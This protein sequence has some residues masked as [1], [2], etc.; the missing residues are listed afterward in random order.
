MSAM[1][2]SRD[3]N[4]VKH[5]FTY[6]PS[7]LNECAAVFYKNIQREATLDKQEVKGISNH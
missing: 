6:I 3:V 4:P 7:L 5:V 1:A 2:L